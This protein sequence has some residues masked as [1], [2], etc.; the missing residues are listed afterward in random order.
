MP[1][2]G[3]GQPALAR[4]VGLPPG[5]LDVGKE[6]IGQGQLP[7]VT[8]PRAG[9]LPPRKAYFLLRTTVPEQER[10]RDHRR[11]RRLRVEPI[12]IAQIHQIEV[13]G[14]AIRDRLFE[15]GRGRHAQGTGQDGGQMIQDRDAHGDA[16]PARP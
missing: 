4:V 11:R 5:L 16:C 14:E 15:I 6:R 12:R 7:L 10:G 9:Y 8:H 1:G 3:A 2:V 13:G